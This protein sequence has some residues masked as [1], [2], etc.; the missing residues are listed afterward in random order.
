MRWAPPMNFVSARRAIDG[1]LRVD[2]K[3]P[4][5]V[6]ASQLSADYRSFG[7]WQLV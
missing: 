2:S 7:R 3:E 5:F 4:E 1:G 6:D